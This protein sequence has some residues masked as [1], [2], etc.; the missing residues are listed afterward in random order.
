MC[1]LSHASHPVLNLML[2]CLGWCN[3]EGSGIAFTIHSKML[4]PI[5]GKILD[6]APS[7]SL[8]F[9]MANNPIEMVY[10]SLQ[11]RKA[12]AVRLFNLQLR[13][14]AAMCHSLELDGMDRLGTMFLWMKCLGMCS[15]IWEVSWCMRS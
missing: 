8:V 2:L 11:L 14:P 12:V 13:R 3:W 1:R 4:T 9:T 5:V 15:Q 10:Q 6:G 7:I